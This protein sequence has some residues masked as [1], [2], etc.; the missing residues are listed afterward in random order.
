MIECSCVFGVLLSI[1]VTAEEGSSKKLLESACQTRD[2]E[3]Q[4][5]SSVYLSRQGL[6][7]SFGYHD[8]RL[9]CLASYIAPRLTRFSQC[10]AAFQKLLVKCDYIRV[11]IY[12]YQYLSLIVS[13]VQQVCFFVAKRRNN[14]P[15][16]MF[17]CC[18]DGA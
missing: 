2:L 15:A 8:Q 9:N 3:T 6:Q 11:I 12:Q 4:G 7:R 18:C 17:C 16:C 13:N 10:L 5:P 14:L 1:R